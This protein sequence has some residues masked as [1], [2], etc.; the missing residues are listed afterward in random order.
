MS[1]PFASQLLSGK[2]VCPAQRRERTS[3]VSGQALKGQVPS[4][5]RASLGRRRLSKSED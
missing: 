1:V 4:P 2:A 5:A 3:H